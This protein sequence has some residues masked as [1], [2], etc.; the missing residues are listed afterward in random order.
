MLLNKSVKGFSI[1]ELVVV[2]AIL[3]LL[4]TL[5]L[6][7][8]QLILQR[9]KEHQ[10]RTAL[11]DIRQAIDAYYKAYADGK[12][13][14]MSGASGYPPDLQSLV[15]GVND[16]TH[17]G[18]KRMY[19]LRRIPRDPFYPDNQVDAADTWGLRSYDS[20]YENPREGDDVFDVYSLSEQLSIS[21][22]PYRQW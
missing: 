5:A 17:P 7:S 13:Q 10:L 12:L 18:Q 4:G 15:E 22:E 8:A 19:F 14:K 16:V 1:I 2:M 3:A 9:N 6:P 20:D 11:H 21:G